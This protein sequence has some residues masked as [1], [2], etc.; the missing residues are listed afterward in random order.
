MKNPLFMVPYVRGAGFLVEVHHD[1]ALGPLLPWTEAD[2]KSVRT[3]FDGWSGLLRGLTLAGYRVVEISIEADPDSATQRLLLDTATF[4][5]GS[6]GLVPDGLDYVREGAPPLLV[7]ITLDPLWP[8]GEPVGAPLALALPIYDLEEIDGVYAPVQQTARGWIGLTSATPGLGGSLGGLISRGLDIGRILAD[9][10]AAGAWHLEPDA[11]VEPSGLGWMFDDRNWWFPPRT[12]DRPDANA[13]VV[14]DALTEVAKPLRT[15]GIDV[16]EFLTEQIVRKHDPHIFSPAGSFAHETRAYSTQ[17]P[18]AAADAYRERVSSLA[19]SGMQVVLETS[20]IL[21][22]RFMWTDAVLVM[23][24]HG[25]VGVAHRLLPGVPSTALSNRLG[26]SIPEWTTPQLTGQWDADASVGRW[27][28]LILNQ[29]GTVISGFWQQHN[30]T[31]LTRYTIEGTQSGGDREGGP[32]SFAVECW[33]QPGPADVGPFLTTAGE[34]T[35]NAVPGAAPRLTLHMNLATGADVYEFA[36][37]AGPIDVAHETEWSMAGL[38]DNLKDRIRTLRDAPLHYEEMKAAQFLLLT[39]AKYIER[40]LAEEP[41][42]QGMW[43][44]M[45]DFEAEVNLSLADA[46]PFLNVEELLATAQYYIKTE[47]ANLR[48]LGGD[49]CLSILMLMFRLSYIHPPSLELQRIYGLKV[50]PEGFGDFRYQWRLLDVSMVPVG[51]GVSVARGTGIFE[52]RRV[53]EDL[54]PIGP[55]T[56]RTIDLVAGQADTS[57]GVADPG[58]IDEWQ[59]LSRSTR[60]IVPKLDGATLSLYGF[61][62]SWIIAESGG[63]IDV[64]LRPND[65]LPPLTGQIYPPLLSVPLP[66]LP[67]DLKDVHDAI[68]QVKELIETIKKARAKGVRSL[69]RPLPSVRFST[70]DGWIRTDLREPTVPVEGPIPIESYVTNDATWARFELDKY[71]VTPEFRDGIRRFLRWNLALL[72]GLG[73]M[74]IE[75]NASQVGPDDYN[76][77]LSRDRATSVLTAIYDILGPQLALPCGDIRVRALGSSQSTG[78]PES[79]LALDRRVDVILAGS[80]RMRS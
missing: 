79:D 41:D 61:G 2:V 20:A 80:V 35:V 22:S 11:T 71:E 27:D 14:R 48:P 70:L 29:A 73:E 62:A 49:S 23:I 64:V 33:P 75:G 37:T 36:K 55:V 59:D 19:I 54:N 8:F 51:V 7:V 76:V 30:P 50:F 1:A 26:V 44:L 67:E 12:P 43:A 58:D 13:R 34:I 10:Q 74:V 21:D 18:D 3:L 28:T 40:F 9:Q 65:S 6:A 60:D 46:F 32:L 69:R 72:T 24:E 53:D 31:G 77:R 4:G 63:T 47:L 45:D 38:S 52:L 78:D 39:A 25:A 57:L 15:P 5:V 17:A 66:E 68:D 42:L 56:A 16:A